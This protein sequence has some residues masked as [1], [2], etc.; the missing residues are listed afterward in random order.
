MAVLPFHFVTAATAGTATLV[1]HA[2]LLGWR[3]EVDI[4]N[5]RL[6]WGLLLLVLKWA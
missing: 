5:C 2:A 3:C 1:Q 4:I 6:Q